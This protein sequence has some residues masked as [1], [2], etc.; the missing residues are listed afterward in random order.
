M[1]RQH[2]RRSC[3]A[4]LRGD[5]FIHTSVPVKPAG[6]Q[7]GLQAAYDITGRNET[8]YYKHGSLILTA[9][10]AGSLVIR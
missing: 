5:G 9:A 6:H 10:A 4:N 3:I 8:V 1:L 2:A 7:M